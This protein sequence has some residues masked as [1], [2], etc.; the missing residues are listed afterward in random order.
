MIFF[1][2]GS[3]ALR[4]LGFLS[5]LFSVGGGKDEPVSGSD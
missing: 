3:A 5:K 2:C 4:L 1:L